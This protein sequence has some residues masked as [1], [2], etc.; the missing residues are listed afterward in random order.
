MTEVIDSLKRN[1]LKEYDTAGNLT[2]LTDPLKRVTTNTYNEASQLTE[3]SYSDGITHAVKYE[4]NGDGLPT[5]M[6]DGTGET[7]TTYDQL[8]RIT[9]TEDGH[10]DKTA[11]EY[12]LDNEQTKIT[13]PNTKA[14]TRAFDKDGR[15]E[16]VTDWLT[17]A[18]K[19][20]YDADSSLTATVFPTATSNEDKYTYNEAD[21]LTEIK[22]SKGA[23]TLATLGY[24]RDNNGQ[25]KSSTQ[26]G[27]PGEVTSLYEYDPNSRLT[28]AGPAS[29]EYDAANNPTK[30]GSNSYTF[31][32]ASELEKG[33]GTT[34][35]TY[36]EQGQ[37]TKTTPTTGPASTYGYDQA[38]N[39]TS[40]NRPEEGATPKIE[41][42]YGYDGSGLRASQTINGTTTYMTWDTSESVPLVL[43]DTTNSYVYGP[44]NLPIEAISAGGTVLY[45]HHDRAGSTRM[46]SGSTGTEEGA[47]TYDT[48]GNTTGTTGTASAPLRY[49][50]EYA[51]VDTGL[52]YLRARTYDPATG[53]FLSID[54]LRKTTGAPYSYA[55]DNPLSWGDPLG[56][57]TQECVGPSVNLLVF[58]I[59]AE[60]CY[61]TTPGGEGVTLS[62]SI[63]VGLGIGA[64]FH[65]G[66]G[67]SNACTTGEYGGFFSQK[68]ASFSAGLTGGT[69][70]EFSNWP[71][72]LLDGERPVKGWTAGGAVGLNADTGVG[73]SYSFVWSFSGSGESGSGG[74]E[75]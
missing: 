7:I 42:S 21:Q 57:A 71:F 9:N 26:T 52:V 12:D 22:M 44:E 18:T 28:K 1:T 39:L 55:K 61:V 47:L 63:G 59:G 60:V 75:C 45:L 27:L 20:T 54:P 40:I 64:S 51:G 70:T 72:R 17:N 33:P 58:T 73:G 48:Y 67:E 29:Y 68:G 4:Y 16:K 31:D 19:F 36:N 23:E 3:T 15:L 46:L 56:L 10:K 74:C 49:D 37:R 32:V 25:V 43:S 8:D 50:S 41:D 14:V 11:Y 66:A 34:K 53:Q 5:K 24:T 38:E 30:L 2:K 69:Y 6:T 62:P 35:Y 65:Y 13:Y